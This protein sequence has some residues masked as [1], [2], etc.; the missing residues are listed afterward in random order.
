MAGWSSLAAVFGDEAVP[1]VVQVVGESVRIREQKPAFVGWTPGLAGH[2][3]DQRPGLVE[4]LRGDFRDLDSD[5]LLEMVDDGRDA[6]VVGGGRQP[7]RVEGQ[8]WAGGAR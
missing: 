5:L 7:V 6:G 3:L 4:S 8:G 2:L 1:A